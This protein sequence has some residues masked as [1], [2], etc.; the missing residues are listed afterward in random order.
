MPITPD[1]SDATLDSAE[2]AELVHYP[3]GME[4]VGLAS[5]MCV[6]FLNFLL[7]NSRLYVNLCSFITRV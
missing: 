7:F 2:E 3:N 1:L 4:W 5:L 6:Y